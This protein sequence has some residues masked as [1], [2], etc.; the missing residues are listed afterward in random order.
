MRE[1][2]YSNKVDIWAIGCILHEL[3]GGEKLFSKDSIVLDYHQSKTTLTIQCDDKFDEISKSVFTKTILEI[4]HPDARSRPTAF[5]LYEKFRDFNQ[6]ALDKL[7]RIEGKNR[8][9]PRQQPGSS[10]LAATPNCVRSTYK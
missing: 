1:G 9:K 6:L 7:S 10:S 5:V 4:L 2:G 3:L 8:P